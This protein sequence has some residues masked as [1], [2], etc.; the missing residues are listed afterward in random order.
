[1]QNLEGKKG[2]SRDSKSLESFLLKEKVRQTLRLNDAGIEAFLDYNF[3]KFAL[4]NHEGFIRVMACLSVCLITPFI[5]YA[6]FSF[7]GIAAR[8]FFPFLFFGAIA[9]AVYRTG[10]KSVQ[11]FA[12]IPP[13]R[14]IILAFFGII[15]V[16][17]FFKCSTNGGFVAKTFQVIVIGAL[18]YGGYFIRNVRKMKVPVS[19]ILI[20]AFFTTGFV[21]SVQSSFVLYA[22]EREMEILETQAKVRRLKEA[23]EMERLIASSKLC[24]NEE[25]CN[26]LNKKKNVYYSEHEEEAQEIC[27]KTVASEIQERFEWT[28]GAKDYKFT[29][30]KVDVLHDSITV[31]GD[32]AQLVHRD[33]SRTKISY[34]C[35]Y[36]VKAKT[37]TATIVKADKEKAED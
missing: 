5:Y 20:G 8:F 33:G 37:A 35:K 21:F 26:K 25:D 32:R 36:N 22:M 29:S 9:F 13:F 2:K 1:M 16:L 27:E 7:F 17:M 10:Y 24:T 14:E 6:L 4:E 11:K 15:A 34:S 31:M 30:Y 12:D 19:Q 23:K 18:V 28:V 3:K